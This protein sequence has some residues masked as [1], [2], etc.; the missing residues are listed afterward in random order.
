MFGIIHDIY[1]IQTSTRYIMNYEKIYNKIIDYR[2]LNPYNGY[3]EEHHI[4]PKALGGLDDV[5]NLVRLTAREHFICHYLLTK[6]YE[7]GSFEWHKMNHA[8]I[9]MK[10]RSSNQQRYFNSRLYESTKRNF[11]EVMSKV[12]EGKN[13]SQFGTMWISNIELKENRKIKKSD[14][15]PAGWVLGRNAW[16]KMG[17]CDVCKVSIPSKK[18]MWC[19][20]CRPKYAKTYQTTV[21]RA[22]KTKSS[23][24]DDEKRIALEKTGGR[25]R[26]AL[27]MLGL[28]DSGPQYKKMREIKNK[29]NFSS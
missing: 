11:S 6:M 26:R 1:S 29:M 15:I 4:L 24:T 18:A 23:Y 13:N 5:D 17:T 2:K 3:T 8:F 27:Y 21:F 14:I 20:T 19:K 16:N 12:Q 10:S 25:I 9:I 7:V 22:T 28:S